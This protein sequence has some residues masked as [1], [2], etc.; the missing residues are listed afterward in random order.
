MRIATTL[1][2]RPTISAFVLRRGSRRSSSSLS[3]ALRVTPYFTVISPSFHHSLFNALKPWFLGTGT[4]SKESLWSYSFVLFNCYCTYRPEELVISFL[5]HI[6]GIYNR[7][8][9]NIR[10]QGGLVLGECWR[11]RSTEFRPV[12][13]KSFLELIW[14][15]FCCS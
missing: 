11:N 2:V 5:Y 10:K 14:W 6:Q 3:I 9:I 4:P 13:G 8:R 7:L 12:E 1:H 15:S